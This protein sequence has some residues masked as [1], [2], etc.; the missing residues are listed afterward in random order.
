MDAIRPASYKGRP[1]PMIGMVWGIQ[2]SV[3]IVI[4]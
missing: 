1:V 4:T 2:M 3:S